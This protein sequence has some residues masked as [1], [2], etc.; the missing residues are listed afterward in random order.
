MKPT[1]FATGLVLAVL[2]GTFVAPVF[3][4]DQPPPPCTTKQKKNCT[5][6]PD[7]PKDPT[8]PK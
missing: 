4:E 2:V 1:L 5:P 8:S 3:A 7:H 6:T